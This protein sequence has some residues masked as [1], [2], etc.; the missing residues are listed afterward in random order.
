MLDG[1][2]RFPT[3]HK[4]RVVFVCEDDLWAVSVDG[5]VARRLTA[6]LGEIS[7]PSLSPDGLSVAFVG[8]EEGQPD[9]YSM[10]A[11]GGHPHRL[12]FLGDYACRT[13]GWTADGRI[14]LSH[15]AGQ[16]FDRMS[17]LYTLHADNGLLE[18][19]NVGPAR[20]ISFGPDGGVVIGNN[21]RSPAHWKRYRG[22]RTG[23]IW[24]DRQGDGQFESLLDLRGNLD[25]PIW[26]GER[27][28]F[29]SDHEGIGN[30][31]SCTPSGEEIRRHTD[32]NDFY[33]R[34]ASSDGRRIVYHA[35]ADLYIFDPTQNGSRQIPI[36]HY[37]SQTQ[38]N[39]KFVY[40]AKYLDD[41]TLH[42]SG[43]AVAITSR[44]KP[45]TFPNWDGAVLQHGQANGVRYR[46]LEWLNDGQRMI[47]VSDEGGEESFVLFEGDDSGVTTPT[48]FEGLDIGRPLAVK[49]NPKKDQ[50]L[51]SN[52]R[53]ELLCLDLTDRTLTVIDRSKV[54]RISGFDWSPD[55]EWVA[56]GAS[57]SLQRTALKLWKAESGEIVALTDPV[58]HDI[59][60]SFDPAGKYLYFLSYR[61]FDPVAD[62]IHFDLGFPG[63]V[64]PFLITLQ[65]NLKSP[66]IETPDIH[67]LSKEDEDGA[68]KKAES[69][70]EPEADGEKGEQQE[71][72]KK[73]SKSETAVTI[74]IEG[75]QDRI[76]AFPVPDGR[77]GRIA[78]VKEGKVLYTRFP[79]EGALNQSRHSAV[80]PAKGSLYVYDFK[81]REE[82]RILSRVTSFALNRDCSTVIVR[83]G[84]RLRVI[85][86]GSKPK[87]NGNGSGQK[88]GW[89]NLSRVK[90][91]IIPVAEW[92]QMYGEAW[93]LQRDHYWMPDMSQVDWLAVY[94]RY[95][96]LIDR[97]VSRSEFSDLIWEMQGE[98]G[99]S[100]AYEMGGDYRTEP[101]YS[102]GYLG[103]DLHFD[104]AVDKW[105][106][107]HIVQGD[108][109]ND[110]ADS[111]LNKPGLG[112]KNGDYLLAINGQAI[113]REMSPQR[114]LVNLAGD[115]ILLT[116]ASEIEVNEKSDDLPR[117][118]HILVKT[119]RSES[120][121]RYREWVNKNRRHVFEATN[122]RVG[123]VH[124]PDMGAHGYAEFHRG[125]LAE[126]DRESLIVDVRYN[127]GGNVSELILEKL[128]RRRIGYDLTRWSELPYPYPGESVH[129]PLV[130]L[131]NE[132]AGSDGDI[133]SHSFKLMGLGPLVGKRTWGG[134][135]GIYPRHALVDGTMT[136]QP[137][138]SFWF[139]DV[140]WGVENYGTDPDIEVA[141]RPQDYAL[142][143]DAQLEKAI[144]VVLELLDANPPQIPDFGPPP[145]RALP[146]LGMREQGE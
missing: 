80:P 49:V 41:W 46:L 18:K 141:N 89:L 1:Y 117:P 82:K 58:L 30:I 106:I 20:T 40:T 76:I 38:R 100:H 57:I 84:S 140:G 8:R 31:Y 98:L 127:R 7:W 135:I 62:N 137:E 33:A 28:Y 65:E 119:L 77:Y 71:G 90:V 66:F 128:A 103:A 114:A 88:S 21:L 85:K 29:L 86:A 13:A 15:S 52:H 139:Q 25:S 110:G 83:S 133:F 121:A 4:N 11:D 136:T 69:E 105:Q 26:L 120:V 10:A 126:I 34:N 55:G 96:P 16:P 24:V 56:Y 32:H 129:G 47:A 101:T 92:R 115:D 87:E 59:Q 116:V 45:F 81:E 27:I 79:V 43:K 108:V 94:D 146:R 39:R 91:S 144:A 2:Y 67:A 23:Q 125:Y 78:G 5:G 63:G 64:R 118:R 122:G 44:G 143:V 107:A 50:V 112:V 138:F 48:V 97:V 123:Y 142:G 73:N 61:E 75:I 131:T 42:P 95:L 74:D 111:S 109:W 51:F 70:D 132:Y 3:I 22:G 124:I 102:Q 6:G 68:G 104:E 14:L 19:V 145:S 130:A 35:G 53:Y 134:V 113:N 54:S 60:P 17:H 9:I 99:T 93:R 37:S 36:E 12:T 72:E